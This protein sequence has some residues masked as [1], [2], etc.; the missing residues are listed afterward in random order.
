MNVEDI[1]PLLPGQVGMLVRTLRSPGSGVYIEQRS[2][3]VEGALDVD[4]LRES[5]RLLVD[6]HPALR[7]SVH[8]EGVDQP[9]QV[10]H[11][12]AEPEVRVLDAGEDRAEVT[13]RDSREGFALDRAPLFRLTVLPEAPGRWYLLWT[14]HHVILDGWSATILLQ[15]FFAV[16]AELAEGGVPRLAPRPH[17]GTIVRNALEA[18]L[19]ESRSFWTEH[20]AGVG[21]VEPIRL[22]GAGGRHGYERADRPLPGR[23]TDAVKDFAARHRTTP[24]AVYFAAWQLQLGAFGDDDLVTG[25]VSSG[26]NS[27]FVGADRAVGLLLN[28]LPVRTRIDRD[29]P[30]TTFLRVCHEAMSACAEHDRVPLITLHEW[31]DRPADQPWFQALFV[32]QNFP[33]DRKMLAERENWRISDLDFVETTDVPL[34]MMIVPGGRIGDDGVVYLSYDTAYVGPTAATDVIA[35]YRR[36]LEWLLTEPGESLRDTMPRLAVRGQ[37]EV[38]AARGTGAETS[39]TTRTERVLADIW[40]E[41]LGVRVTS[42]HANFF[43]IGGQS[44]MA[45]RVASKVRER[46]R[47]PLPVE[48]V[49]AAPVLAD[50]AA[51][52]DEVR[53]G[54][55]PAVPRTEPVGE[56][57]GLPAYGLSPAQQRLWFLDELFPDSGA[58]L[59]SAAVR[60]DGPLDLALLC[61]AVTALV[62]RHEVLRTTFPEVDGTPRAVVHPVP[63]VRWDVRDVSEEDLPALLSDEACRR[64]D[65][66]VE[67]ALRVTCCRLAPARAVVQLCLHHLVADEWSMKVMLDDLV[68]LYEA[69]AQRR[70]ADLVELTHRYVDYA[71]YQWER[72][73]GDDDAE[74][75][76]TALDGVAAD[77]ALPGRRTRPARPTFRGADVGFSVDETDV[78]RLLDVAEERGTT[79]FAVLA[80]AVSVVL[81][82][83]SGA[84]R[85]AL[86]TPVAQR[87]E[88]EFEPLVGLMV[89]TVPFAVDVDPRG[90]VAELVDEVAASVVGA[91]AHAGTGFDRIVEALPDSRASSG[92]PLF[93]VLVALHEMLPPAHTMHGLELNWLDVAGRSAQFDLCVR[94]RVEDGAVRGSVEY[95]LDL[96]DAD[97]VVGFTAD[98]VAVLE[99]LPDRLDSRIDALSRFDPVRARVPDVVTAPA[100]LVPAD[101]LRAA[102]QEVLGVDEVFD[103]DDFF[104]LGGDSISLVRVRSRLAAAGYHVPLDVLYANPRFGDLGDAVPTEPTVPDVRSASS[105]K[106]VGLPPP[107]GTQCRMLDE[108]DRESADA[109]YVVSADY[110]ADVPYEPEVLRRVLADVT[111]RHPALRTGFRRDA[112]GSWSQQVAADVAPAF[113]TREL[114]PERYDLWWAA[115]R[116][117]GFDVGEP[118]LIRWHLV[119]TGTDRVRFGV[120]VHHAIIDGMSLSSLLAQILERYG[121]RLRGT[122]PEALAVDKTYPE[123][124]ES[125]RQEARLPQALPFWRDELASAVP[126]RVPLIASPGD[127]GRSEAVDHVLPPDLVARLTAL[128]RAEHVSTRLLLLAAHISVVTPPSIGNSPYVATGLV[129]HG[130]TED[131]PYDA[132]GN[133]LNVVPLVLREQPTTWRRLVRAVQVAEAG[134]LP[135]LGCPFPDIQR[136]LGIREPFTAL[137]NFVHF[138]HA[139]PT[140]QRFGVRLRSGRDPFPQPVAAHFRVDPL[141]GTTVLALHTRSGCLPAGGA[142]SLARQYFR[143]FTDLLADPEAAPW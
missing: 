125:A 1:Y 81:A 78:K 96:Y 124:V 118:G 26:R 83:R 123:F 80:V 132:V 130:R 66:S 135:H 91:L 24:A 101:A 56:H 108:A 95:A 102:W 110:E 8:W 4:L 121:T 52:V 43:A 77:V 46:L 6:H 51:R 21:A 37:R 54:T 2:C 28:T 49:F 86:G 90:G 33:F 31:C 79:L 38:R 140:G 126:Q 30:V 29:A 11:R 25:V 120:V 55:A 19:T 82:A 99:A 143:A 109:T 116:Y 115:E 142:E 117:R 23:I 114:T 106:P 134:V 129:L 36:V 5:W 111:A 71:R 89:D 41:L 139:A 75:W 61:D 10:V 72:P 67:P 92:N 16:Y 88:P 68:E 48:V 13:R 93:Q 22:A 141:D 122:E 20:L 84:R 65:L 45:M 73:F 9:V 98:L 137:F 34:S 133:F 138:Q 64:F 112:L 42:A 47:V 14:M 70:P 59:V 7:T 105:A 12:T 3:T 27:A 85:F 60:I 58:Y 104:S 131:V 50:C 17:P 32:V 63:D 136:A 57:N 40:S 103:G 119:R 100:V 74:Y 76:R 97:T 107:T 62:M 53:V 15:E 94:A 128:A 39:L 44:L 18:D 87:P 69:A 127:G 35:D 113:T